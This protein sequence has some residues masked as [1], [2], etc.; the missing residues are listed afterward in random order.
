MRCE[1]TRRGNQ[2]RLET[3][4]EGGA[5]RRH[6]KI[7]AAPMDQSREAHHPA[8]PHHSPEGATREGGPTHDAPRRRG[9]EVASSLPWIPWMDTMDRRTSAVLGRVFAAR[10]AP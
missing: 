7:A 4:A 10:T 6:A 2:G 8:R 1:T 9:A 3:A 5:D